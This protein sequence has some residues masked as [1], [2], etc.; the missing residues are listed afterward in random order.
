MDG[1]GSEFQKQ[2]AKEGRCIPKKELASLIHSYFGG[3]VSIE[4]IDASRVLSLIGC[5]REDWRE[6]NFKET[7]MSS[8]VI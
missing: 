8:S 7:I 1:E 2:A 5:G 6:A 4:V 3:K